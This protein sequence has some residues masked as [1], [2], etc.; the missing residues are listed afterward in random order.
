MIGRF[1]LQD[2][3]TR[4]VDRL[5]MGQRQRLRLAMAFLHEPAVV[6]LDEPSTSLD[7]A[8]LE[9]LG[10]VMDEHLQAG[11][12]AVWMGPTGDT[13]PKSPDLHLALVGGSLAASS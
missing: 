12:S 11:R 2:F 7:L 13:L 1:A 4:R 6:L 9:T 3:A 10:A 5:S 8:G